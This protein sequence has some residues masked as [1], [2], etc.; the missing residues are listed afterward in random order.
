MRES[1]NSDCIDEMGIDRNLFDTDPT[2]PL[3]IIEQ[4]YIPE[5]LIEPPLNDF[6]IDEKKPII[7]EIEKDEFDDGFDDNNDSFDDYENDDDDD[8]D[9]KTPEVLRIPFKVLRFKN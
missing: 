4:K 9:F 1:I 6:E 2:K 8:E 7:E 3:H 5:A